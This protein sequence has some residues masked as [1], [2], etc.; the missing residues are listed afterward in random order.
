VSWICYRGGCVP[1][2]RSNHQFTSPLSRRALPE[3][4][5]HYKQAPIG[6]SLSGALLLAM[7]FRSAL[8]RNFRRSITTFPNPLR[9]YK[10][11]AMRNMILLI[12]LVP[13]GGCIYYNYSQPYPDYPYYYSPPP[14][15]PSYDYRQ[16]LSC[17]GPWRK[18][19]CQSPPAVALHRPRPICSPLGTLDSGC[20][21][22][23]ASDFRCDHEDSVFLG[24]LGHGVGDG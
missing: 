24:D 23:P 2:F 17:A 11:R 1:W 5:F 3:R 8:T 10:Q 14:P 4:L 22:L 20:A 13:L 18:W 15:P 16:P 19:P 7:A 21:E 12:T 6:L 9:S